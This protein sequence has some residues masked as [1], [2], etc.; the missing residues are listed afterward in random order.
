MPLSA[1]SPGAQALFLP[2][3]AQPAVFDALTRQID[4]RR[5]R[6]AVLAG[7]DAA[8]RSRFPAGAG[9]NGKPQVIHLAQARAQ[10]DVQRL[11]REI[12]ALEAEAQARG[13]DFR[14]A[15]ARHIAET[16]RRVVSMVALG[17]RGRGQCSPAMVLQI[18]IAIED[19]NAEI[20]R[21]H[22]LMALAE[23][24]AHELLHRAET[25]HRRARC[26]GDQSPVEVR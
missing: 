24:A 11:E 9:R 5:S 12:G 6:L 26:N 1:P 14:L 2:L 16:Q 21:I 19:A 3:A 17:R 23:R 18:Q 25:S 15:G 13:A 4:E 22:D 8:G 7:Y 10:F 20:D